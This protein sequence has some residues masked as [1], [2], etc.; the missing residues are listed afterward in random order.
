LVCEGV[1]DRWPDLRILVMEGGWTWVPAFADRFD[2]AWA[3]L[4]SEIPHLQRKPSEYIR[5]HF[6]YSTQPLEEPERPEHLE[7]A[8][9][10]LDAP[11]RIVFSSDYPHWDFDPP[12]EVARL[13]PDELREGIMGRNAARLFPKLSH[14]E[15]D[16]HADA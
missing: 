4:R 10:L 2:T 12:T 1:F 16:Q 6:W 15:D 9:A 13:V 5:D 14:L 3:Q 11:D 8:L 7:Q